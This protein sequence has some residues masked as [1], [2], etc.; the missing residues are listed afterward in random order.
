MNSEVVEAPKQDGEQA[1]KQMLYAGPRGTAVKI[2]NRVE[3]TDSYLDKLLDVELKLKELSDLD[4]SLLAEIVHGVM[5]WQGRLDWVLNGFTHGNF[6]KSEVNV[7][8]ALRVAL[9]QILFLTQVPHYAAVNEAV[10]FIKRIR[11]E[12]FSGF[13]N[14]VLRNIIRTLDGIHYPNPEEDLSQYLAVYYSHPVWMVKRWLARF[15]KEELEKMLIANNEM[16]GLTLRINKLKISSPEFLALLEKQN[17]QFQGSTFIDHFLKVKSL[18]GISQMNIFQQ[19]Y[20]TVQDESAALP[21]LLLDPHPGERVIDMCAAPG[22]KTTFIAEMMNNQGEILAVDKYETKLNMIKLSCDR[23]GILNVQLLATDASS[24]ETSLADKVLVDAPC[25]GLGTLRKKPDIKWKR[26]P[27]D[28]KRM[29]KQQSTLL[30]NAARLVKPGG[31]IVYSTCTTEPEENSEVIK[32]FIET[33]PDYSI[34]PASN[35]VNKS[36]VSV[37]GFIETFPHKHHIDG[38]FAA[39]L[40]KKL[41]N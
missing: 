9:Y 39:R 41:P 1:E 21:V 11:G 8:N 12:R 29:V 22:G 6:S 15:G 4:K 32:K 40:R 3:R 31:V 28:L 23:L 13:V 26:E 16:P 17:V 27:E 33:H 24:L 18:S 19:G 35:F 20:F 37:E 36:V 5:R 7:R 25:T 10:E 38:S 2:L 34:E 30:E 14:A